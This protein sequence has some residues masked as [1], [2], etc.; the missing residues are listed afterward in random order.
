MN[1]RP[2]NVKSEYTGGNIWVFWGS[3]GNGKYF[4]TDSANEW[5]YIVDADPDSAEDL[6]AWEYDWQ[7]EHIIDEFESDEFYR[8]VLKQA[9]KNNPNADIKW[10]LDD[11]NDRMKSNKKESVNKPMKL[12]IKESDDF[13]KSKKQSKRLSE[14]KA[15]KE[16]PGA[17]YTIKVKG[18]SD[19]NITSAS[20]VD[21]VEEVGWTFDVSGTCTIDKM[22]ADSYY[23]GTG[24]MMNVPANITK[25][26]VNWYWV[27]EEADTVSNFSDSELVAWINSFANDRL[28]NIE[29][30]TV[31]GGGWMHSTYD[32]T[33]D[34]VDEEDGDVNLVITDKEAIDYIDTAVQGENYAE[35]YVVTD[36]SDTVLEVFDTEEEAVAFAKEELKTG[37][38]ETLTVERYNN[39]WGYGGEYIDTFE[40]GEVVWQGDYEYDDDYEVDEYEG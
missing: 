10:L 29:I 21:Y 8:E 40:D 39:Y 25:I 13:K 6:E 7:Q 2:S 22:S 5:I 37:S 20:F 1:Y 36:E 28:D 17:G 24:E 26:F 35:S 34:A 11:L 16:G 32:G 38:Y 31:F 3:L 18:L 19:I 9:I 33:I 12:T 4:M 15:L 30:E 27:D 23:Y 14:K